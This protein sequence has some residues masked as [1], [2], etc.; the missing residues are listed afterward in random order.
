MKITWWKGVFVADSL[1]GDRA[2]LSRAGFE[3]HEPTTC[4]DPPRC[5]ACRAKIGRRY[6]SNRVEDATKLRQHC[7]PKA[8]SV[9][10]EHLSVLARSRA[11]DADISIPSPE[12]LE[13]RPFQKAG[14]AYALQHKDTLIG[15]DMGLGKTV[16]ALGFVN[17]TRP[18]SVLVVCP[19]T[20]MLNWAGEAERW[21]CDRYEIVIPGTGGEEVPA[22]D[23]SR[24]LMVITNYEKVIG[25]IV[26]N[27]RK[28][29]PL[30]RSLA[31]I[32]DLGVF[33]EVQAL[34]NPE[35]HRTQAV[36]GESG[37]F[38]RCRR[39]LSLTGTPI[40]NYPKEIW[41]LA[42]TICPAKFGDWWGFA[43]RYCGLHK[44]AHGDR[45]TW[46]DTGHAHLAELQQRLRATFMVRRLKADVLKELPPKQRQLVVL[47]DHDVDWSSHPAL[48]KW[49]AAQTENLDTA[50]D[51]LASVKTEAEYRKAV[52]D[53]DAKNGIPFEEM[54]AVR[55]ETALVKVKPC[56]RFTDTLLDGGLEALV[57]Y[58]HHRDV[59][60][61]ILEHYGDHAC[62]IYGDTEIEDRIPIVNLFQS[63]R[64]RIILI[65]LKAAGTGT[66]LTRASTGV[67]FETDW[68][69]A[70]V[71][72]A[73][74]RMHRIGQ[75]KAV[76][77]IHPVLNGT[78]DANMVKKMIAKQDVVDKALDWLPEQV[79]RQQLSLPIR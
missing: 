73:E 67:F 58:A 1:P 2:A 57:I 16:Q 77:I 6:W 52:K 59:L 53:L 75:R 17:V 71:K 20:L 35:A 68:N 44:E 48:L 3:L 11:V 12:G 8:L 64:K 27:E 23:S 36:L 61:Q 39:T 33:D 54:S 15:D 46:V 22:T 29:T 19:A 60:Q 56:L 40:E 63:G 7:T 62:C 78:M 37:L 30:T 28:D 21:L 10:K 26:K 4:E 5:R 18:R 9:M 51:S 79:R 49:R 70:V 72:Q 25:R 31:R 76:N 55:H 45:M 47:D 41:P 74:D 43:K 66:T 42:K 50:L 34:K 38:H 32:W 24:N 13:Y 69:P 65:G 14:V